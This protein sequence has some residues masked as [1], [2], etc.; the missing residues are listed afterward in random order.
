M[1]VCVSLPNLA[2]ETA[3]AA[4]TR[5]SLRPLT[6]K[7]ANETANPG[8]NAPREREGVISGTYLA[9]KRGEV[10]SSGRCLTFESA[11]IRLT[12]A[13]LLRRPRERADP[14]VSAIALIA[15]AAASRM[16]TMADTFP[17]H[18]SRWL[19]VPAFAGTTGDGNCADLRRQ[20]RQAGRLH[21]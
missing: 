20:G 16:G 8:R 14:S 2:R 1:L 9:P 21:V 4:R 15:Y 11:A 5:L 3:G 6:G 12:Q 10:K 13:P 18:E 19:W 7:D 17:D